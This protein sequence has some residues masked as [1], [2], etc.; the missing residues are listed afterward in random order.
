MTGP[1]AENILQVESLTTVFDTRE[2]RIKAVD[3]VSFDLERGQTLGLVGESGCGKSVTA[4]S[5]MGLVPSPPGR[6]ETGRILFNGTDLVQASDDDLRNLRGGDLS[7][8]FQEPM[9]SLNPVFTIG[10][11]IGEVF[12]FHQGMN[13]SESLEAAVKMLDL[14]GI[15]SPEQRVKEYPHNMS[16]GMRQR[17]MIAMALACRPQ[18]MIADEPTTALDVTVQAQI[19]TLMNQL[20]DEINT[21]ILLITHNL[22]VVAQMADW[23][24]VMYMGRIVEYASV[25]AFFD[26]PLHPYSRGLLN[27]LPPAATED[28]VDSLETI[29]GIVPS[30][31]ELPPGCKFE[32]RCP[33]ASS[34][35]SAEEPSLEKIS[36]KHQVRCYN[37]KEFLGN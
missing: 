7:M 3:S 33:T 27:S 18:L 13:R 34:H 5:I 35:C 25:D 9:T 1:G 2:G 19:L 26:Q 22:G 29:D 24:A 23:V 32:D 30:Y 20:K 31:F 17:V 6:I 37:Y 16:G 21:S 10:D 36:E 14:V 28:L 12:K 11:Q 8:I 15:P 4:L